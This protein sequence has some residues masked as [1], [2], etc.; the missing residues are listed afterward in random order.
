M[1]WGRMLRLPDLQR[2][3]FRGI[4]R[5][6][7]GDDDPR[8]DLQ[9]AREIRAHGPLDAAERV[10]IYAAMYCAR[11]VDALAE[12][13][14]R[15]AAILGPDAFG[16]AAHAYVAR[17]PSTRPSLRWFGGQFGEFLAA[18]RADARPG[19]IP[20]LARLEWA[21]LAVFD[22]PEAMLLDIEALRRLPAERW[23]ALRLELAPAVQF[24]QVAWPVHRIW[25]D[26][27][28]GATWLPAETRL[29]V[30]RQGDQVFQAAMDDVER[31][32]VAHVQ[33]G[34]DFAAMCTGLAALVPGD[35]VAATAA[36]LVMRWIE[37]GVL[38]GVTPVD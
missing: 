38:R 19:F 32:A 12:D 3:L 17:H 1:C 34:D 6:H 35:V 21:R 2:A 13:Y 9:L 8:L 11:L 37:D 25:Q 15:V 20:D 10:G 27:P 36:A 16:D 31:T 24:L 26:A 7:E 33:A 30:W 4:T 29:R 18:D 14:P 5:A 23:S 28:V 22:A